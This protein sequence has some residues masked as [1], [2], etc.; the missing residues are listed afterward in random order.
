MGVG[1][2]GAGMWVWGEKIYELSL[3][4]GCRV[5]GYGMWSVGM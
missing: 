4:V 3:G 5:W 2:R 1:V